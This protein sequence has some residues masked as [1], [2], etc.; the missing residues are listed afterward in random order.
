MI[1]LA[2]IFKVIR[3]LHRRPGQKA[4]ELA[5]AC[6]VSVRTVYRYIDTLVNIG[7]PIYSCGGFHILDSN[8]MPPAD[9]SY[10]ELLYLNSL[11]QE[12]SGLVT[13]EKPQAKENILFKINQAFCDPDHHRFTA[14]ADLQNKYVADHCPESNRSKS[15]GELVVT[16]Q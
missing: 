2:R 7:F 4:P 12:K 6:G 9:F 8:Q 13:P 16:H 11:L 5:E 10:L 3:L 1:K 15:I 14:S